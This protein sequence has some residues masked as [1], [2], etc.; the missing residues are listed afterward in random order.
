MRTFE[1]NLSCKKTEKIILGRQGENLVTD[2]IF[3][4]SAWLEEFGEGT[5]S[6]IHQRAHDAAP[7][8]VLL[9]VIGTRALWHV[10]NSDT[11][12]FGLGF[13]ELQ[14]I[15][16][17]QL[18]KSRTYDTQTAR[19]LGTASETP[20]EPWEGWVEAVL[21][22]A[23]RA[24]AA[25]D[26]AEQA[27]VHAP[28]IRDTDKH[29]MVW[30]VER[31]EYVDTG[32]VAEGSGSG[33]SHPYISLSREGAYFFNVTFGTIPPET[34]INIPVGGGCSSY[35]ADGKLC[36]NLDWDYSETASFHVICKGF[37]GMSFLGSLT[38]GNLN[39]R[40]IGQLPYHLNDGRNDYGI[41]VSSHVLYNDWEWQGTGNIPLTKIPFLVLSQ[42]HSLDNFAEQMSAILADVYAPST[43][44]NAE[45]LLQFLVTDGTTT[46]V[47]MPPT[48]SS[49]SYVVV[50]ATANPKLTNFRWVED[51]TV[52][53]FEL[54]NRP[55]GVERWN[56]IPASLEDL[57]FTLAYEAPTR[58]S[59]FIGIRGTDKDSTDAELTAIYNEAHALYEERTRDGRTWQT[60]HSVVYSADKIDHLWVQENYDRD[61]AH[62]GTGGTTDHTQLT[63]RDAA[64]QHPISAITGL[65]DELDDKQ[66]AG[67]YALKEELDALAD[68][69][70]D[71][72]DIIS[73][74]DTIRSG[75]EAGAT[76]VQPNDP[77]SDLAEDASHRTVTDAEKQAWNAKQN[78]LTPDVDYATPEVVRQDISDATTDMATETWV[79]GKGYITADDIPVLS[80]NG[81]V[82]AVVLTA[83]DL[84]I[85]SVFDLKGSVATKTAL[86]S[87][88]NKKG[89]VWYVVDESVGYIWLNDGTTDRWEML[90][91]SVDL[92]NYVTTTALATALNGYVQKIAGKGLS[93]NDFT[94]AYKTKLDS[95]ITSLVGYATEQWVE[96]KGYLTEHQSLAAY[97][98]SAAQDAIDASK[99]D[100]LVSGQNIKTFNGNSILGSGNFTVREMPSVTSVDAGKFARVNA[101]GEWVAEAVPQFTGGDY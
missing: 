42:I 36:R 31:G 20:P 88:G 8:P 48:S 66:P 82:G 55:T 6:L 5:I 95:A 19:A 57:R 89:D 92:S 100:K 101:S 84:G 29:W 85:G 68:E 45:Y 75:A 58:L 2:I 60:M 51:E 43:L 30:D 67:D 76:A 3:D 50:D 34:D 53:R 52:T 61:Y 23:D 47:I 10:R 11:R 14:Y 79:E 81:K 77:I 37:E 93:T 46:Y 59:E 63:N 78:T 54:Q 15:V 4:F 62:G 27:V 91:M 65:Q 69:V 35:V 9:D 96:Q 90:G 28:Y 44:V 38:D 12:D 13:C 87:T 24:E 41:R 7:Y 72:Q 32:V 49:G 73:D 40:L 17:D 99:Q 71:K 70:D 74:L 21:A 39:D 22:A 80:V 56:M 25:A 16:G 18:A 26:R 1:I 94:D 97:R 33:E 98:T 86:P 83:A 64:D